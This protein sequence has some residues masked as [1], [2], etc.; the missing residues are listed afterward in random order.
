MTAVAAV[1]DRVYVSGSIEL[2]ILDGNADACPVYRASYH[3]DAAGSGAMVADEHLV[4]LSAVEGIHVVDTTLADAPRRL[5]LHPAPLPCRESCWLARA[6][7][8]LYYVGREDATINGPTWLQVIDV[9][10]P[11][12]P[13]QVGATTTLRGAAGP[14]LVMGES[15]VVMGDSALRVIDLKSATPR[16]R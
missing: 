1:G 15:L 8:L 9:S 6:G 4:F 14:S 2:H 7:N 16:S 12:A 13:V 11:E 3:L 10:N 5:A